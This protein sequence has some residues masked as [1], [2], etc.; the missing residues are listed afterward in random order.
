MTYSTYWAGS[1]GTNLLGAAGG[2][3]IVLIYA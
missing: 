2:G 3:A 1:Y